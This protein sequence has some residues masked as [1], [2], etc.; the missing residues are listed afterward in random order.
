MENLFETAPFSTKD[1]VSLKVLADNM[2][3]QSLFTFCKTYKR[4][5]EKICKDDNFWYNRL[6]TKYPFLMIFNKNQS[7]KEFYLKMSFYI[8]KL[9]EEFDIPYIPS[10]VFNPETIY[11]TNR[12]NKIAMYNHALYNAARAGDENLSNFL[13]NKG[14][15][16]WY[17]GLTGAARGGHKNLVD[18]FINKGAKDLFVAILQAKAGGHKDLVNYLESKI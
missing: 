8:G 14:A 5:N 18:F 3:D 15:N 17:I 13:I 2:D 9:K 6:K 10:E 1:I 11:K 7:W 4:F 12:F 16:N